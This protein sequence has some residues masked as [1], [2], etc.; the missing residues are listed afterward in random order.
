MH[1]MFTVVKIFLNWV[2][3]NSK[4]NVSLMRKWVFEPSSRHS[5]RE[6]LS[7]IAGQCNGVQQ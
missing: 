1:P 7:S 3:V 6:V 2:V 4:S 5:R